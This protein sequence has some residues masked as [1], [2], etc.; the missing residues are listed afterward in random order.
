M[1]REPRRYQNNNDLE[2]MRDLLRRG[3]LANNGTYYVHPGDLNWWLFYPPLAYDF[4]GSIYLWDDPDRPGQI[5]AWALLSPV[6]E[7]FDVVLQ[8]ELRGTPLAWE[9]YRWAI[10]QLKVYAKQAGREHIGVCWISEED[11]L[12]RT[13]LV[14]QG[15]ALASRDAHLVYDLAV[16]RPSVQLPEGY[17]VRSSRG[18]DE[19]AQRAWAQY[20]AFDNSAAFEVYLQRFT[21]FMHTPAYDPAWDMV[22]AAP[23]GQIGAFCIVWPDP[24]SGVGLFEP[25]GTHPDFQRKGLGKAVM[26]EALDR[27]QMLG[28]RQAIVTTGADH[29]PAIRLY[30]AVGFHHGSQLLFYKKKIT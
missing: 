30:E 3:R 12:M 13:W 19:V 16:P 10:R 14:D 1:F 27:L 28:L 18:L 22:V 24:L 4:W 17:V 5:L 7:T 26:L 9:M 25:V 21:R 29:L 6:G 8:P 15:F 2:A 23:D 20:N 11:T